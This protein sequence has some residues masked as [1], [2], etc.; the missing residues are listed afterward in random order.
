MRKI[1]E[2]VDFICDRTWEKGPL[3]AQYDFSVEAFVVYLN[4]KFFLPNWYL[5]ILAYTQT[6]FERLEALLKGRARH[7]KA[8]T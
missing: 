7:L 1:N 4:F 2:Q 8:A 3:R 5:Q 6:K